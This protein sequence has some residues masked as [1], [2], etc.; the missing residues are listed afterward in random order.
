MDMYYWHN[1]SPNMHNIYFIAQAILSFEKLR[2]KATEMHVF[3][4]VY[5]NYFEKHAQE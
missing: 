3:Q 1:M 4:K 5:R 2:Q